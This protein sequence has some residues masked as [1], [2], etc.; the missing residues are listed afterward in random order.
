M[1]YFWRV[2]HLDT[3]NASVLHI[4][5]HEIIGARL[6]T[7]SIHHVMRRARSQQAL[8]AIQVTTATGN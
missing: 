8:S 6:N 4:K 5:L 1:T 3:I 2:E 7:L